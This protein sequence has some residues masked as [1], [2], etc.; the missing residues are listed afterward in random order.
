MI[1]SELNKIADWLAV[2]KLSLNIEKKIWYTTSYHE[3]VITEKDIPCLMKITPYLIGLPSLIFWVWQWTNIWI[4]LARTEI[5]NKISNTAGVMNRQKR[6]LRI[7]AMKLM[8]YS[9]I[10]SQYNLE[11]QIEAS[12]GIAYQNLKDVPFGLNWCFEW[13]CTPK[14]KKRALRIMANS[15]YN[16]H[17][18]PLF[19]TS[20][21]VKGYIRSTT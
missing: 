2:N 4:E 3:R 5:A 17:T 21:E 14:F 15:R 10:L 16:S 8:F 19:I 20:V 1:T 6:Y 7:S 9:L 12:N 13:D 11:I 18:Q